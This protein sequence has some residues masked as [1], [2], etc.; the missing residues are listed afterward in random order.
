[1]TPGV[2]GPP[3]GTPRQRIRSAA[4]RAGQPA[5]VDACVRLL[6]HGD[7]VADVQLLGVLG[8]PHADALLRRGLPADQ[9]YWTRVWALRG[10]LWVWEDAAVTAVATALEDPSWRV[11]EMAAKVVARHLV[12]D[13][14]GPVAA[15][16]ADAVPR[17]RQAADRAVT[18][19]TAAGA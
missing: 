10:L 19:L 12:G 11:R 3:G 13:L 1:M 8:G 4:A 18:R 15:L 6:R 7:P 14:L 9:A 17:V 2:G 16:R 5:F